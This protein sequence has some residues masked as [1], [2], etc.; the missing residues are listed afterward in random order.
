MASIRKFS[1]AFKGK[2][3]RD[4]DHNGLKGY[5]AVYTVKYVTDMI[6][7]FDQE[8]FAEKM[9]GLT[10]DVENHPGMLLTTSW[11]DKGELSRESFMTQ[12]VDGKQKVIGTVPAN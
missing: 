2:Y 7:G 4:T 1:D 8:A 10:L 5:V 12:V 11:D 9:H 6:G 3:G